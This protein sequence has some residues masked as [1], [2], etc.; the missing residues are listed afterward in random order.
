LVG[1]GKRVDAAGAAG[2]AAA[3]EEL[4][5]GIFHANSPLLSRSATGSLLAADAEVAILRP[6]LIAIAKAT[7]QILKVA[8][9]NTNRISCCRRVIVPSYSSTS[10]LYV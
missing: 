10:N 7:T 6:K 1:V 4:A 5:D 3:S 8:S 2:A 9:P